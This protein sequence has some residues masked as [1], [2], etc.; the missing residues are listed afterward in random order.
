MLSGEADFEV[1]QILVSLFDDELSL[2]NQC[3]DIVESF[4]IES[5]H[6]SGSLER[7][8][9]LM[10]GLSVHHVPESPRRFAHNGA[11]ARI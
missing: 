11:M 1:R 7:S 5:I 9:I 2:P 6:F 3:G 8:S 4:N 10:D